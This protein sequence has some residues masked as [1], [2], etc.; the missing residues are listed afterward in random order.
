MLARAVQA[1]LEGPVANALHR[2]TG[3][4]LGRS[5]LGVCRSLFGE[6]ETDNIFL[7]LFSSVTLFLAAIGQYSERGPRLSFHF[8]AALDGLNNTPAPVCPKTYGSVRAL[9]GIDTRGGKDELRL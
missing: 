1:A 9:C 4:I 8:Q 6:G 5:I 7:F 3:R 2:R